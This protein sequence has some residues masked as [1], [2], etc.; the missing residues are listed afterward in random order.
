M[1][2]APATP[3]TAVPLQVRVGD[4]LRWPDVPIELLG[5]TAGLDRHVRW[6]QATELLDPSPFL[7]GGEVVLTTGLELR[8]AAECRQFVDALVRAGAVAIGYGVDV[9]TSRPPGPL[10][11]AADAAGLPVLRVPRTVP[12][13]TF[14]ERLAQEQTRMW[15]LAQDRLAAGH[16]FDAVRR[17]LADPVVLLERFGELDRPGVELAAACFAGR[18]RLPHVPGPHRVGY[19]RDRTLVLGTAGTVA[20]LVASMAGD[21]LLGHGGPA[22]GRDVR[23]VLGEA[24]AALDVALGRGRT[25][26]PRDLASLDGLLHRLTAEQ[27]E[28]FRDHV[29]RPIVEH[30][31]R[32]SAALLST[33]RAFLAHDGSVARTAT[34]LYL[35]PNTVRK[36]LD[37]IDDLT[38]LEVREPAGRVALRIA[39]S[40]APPG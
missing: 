16:L 14:T 39:L 6:A 15:V 17:G 20:E 9:V 19:V 4:M 23:R 33:A 37:R 24:V 35:H 11:E 40:A 30:D 18:E 8:G 12:F 29:L 26:G 34:E 36:R 25:A 10:L 13:V 1:T 2:E 5:S 28:P 3:A 32:R 31:R 22:A 7:R 21:V 38:G 27:V